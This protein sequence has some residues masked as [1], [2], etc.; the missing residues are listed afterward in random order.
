M[1]A[2]PALM[3]LRKQL[4]EHPCGTIKRGMSQGYFLRRRLVTVRGE[5]RLTI[6][7]Y[8]MKRVMTIL[9]V[10]KMLAAVA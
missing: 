5:M 1:A 6:L 8:N 2:N 3:T 7:A 9:G 4:A 10:E